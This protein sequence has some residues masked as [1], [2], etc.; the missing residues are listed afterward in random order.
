MVPRLRKRLYAAF[1]VLAWGVVSGVIVA[2]FFFSSFFPEFSLIVVGDVGIAILVVPA[3]CGFVLGIMLSEYEERVVIYGS[4]LLTAVSMILIF[5]VLFLPL[6][7]GI[8]A[9]ISQLG[10]TDEERQAVVLS[11]IFILPISLIGGVAGKAFGE[12]Y[13]PSEEERALRRMLIQ[14]TEKWHE[15]LQAYR[16][17][18]LREEREEME[19]EEEKSQD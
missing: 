15:M 9:D 18:K 7:T 5:L 6:I 11:A 8:A 4:F 14:E 16:R 1:S 19:A 13:L 2:Y 17:E 3:F 10:S 12:T